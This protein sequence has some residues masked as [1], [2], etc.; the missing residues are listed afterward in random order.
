MMSSARRARIYREQ[1]R[2]YQ[3]QTPRQRRRFVRKLRTEQDRIIAAAL[4]TGRHAAP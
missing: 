1:M 4:T 2:T 3:T